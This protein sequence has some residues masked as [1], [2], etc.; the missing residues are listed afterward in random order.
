M[1][2]FIHL[3]V[4][5][6][7]SMLESALTV[8]KIVELAKAE[9]M[10]AVAM[11]DRGNLFGSLEFAISCSKSGVQPIIGSILNLSTEGL[12]KEEKQAFA[13]I[14]LIAKNDTGYKNLLKLVSYTFIKNDRSSCNHITFKDLTE[15]QEGL[16]ALSCYT[17][18]FIG[19]AL[20]A[21][22][23]EKAKEY[24][25]MLQVLFGDRFYFEIMRDTRGDAAAIE[26]GYLNLALEM[27]IPLVAT[28]RVLFSD[29]S[30]HDAH[31]TL[32]CIS[33]GVTKENDNRPRASNQCYFK[34]TSEM[35]Q[36]FHDLPEAIENSI[37]IA[38]RCH[39]MPEPHPPMLPNFG[40]TE[41]SE[42]DLI[43]EES[44]KGLRFR[45]EGKF[46]LEN[47]S[48]DDQEK[49]TKE[50]FARLEYEL[51]IITKMK[52]S[53]YFLIVSDFIKWSKEHNISVGPGR[54]SGAGSIV[55]WCLLITDLDPI[56]FGLLF[57]RFLNPERISMPDFDIDFCQERREEV[58]SYV[59][60]K[61][62]DERVG[63]IIT[64]G[65][66]QAKAVIKDV[67]RVLG[68]KYDLANH[69]TD[70][71]PFN[72]VNPVT[73]AQAIEEVAE[74]GEASKGRG[75]YNFRGDEELIK[76][77]LET[78]LTLE[79]LHRHASTHAA[80]I[81]IAGKDLIEVVP[82]YKDA[83]S[84]MLV[85]QYS[86]KYA[87]AAGLMKFD[88]LGLQTL[89]IITK[90]LELLKA[91]GIE[92][93]FNN[94]LYDDPQTY[95]LLSTGQSTGVFQFESVGM[96]D[97]LRRLRPDNINDIIALGALYRP[98]PMDN[99]PTYIACKHGK[100]QPDYLHPSLKDILESTYGVII[101]QEQVQ[102]IA[103][104][105]AGYTL[106]AA[107]LLRRAMGKKIK[108]EMQAQEEMFISGAKASGIAEQQA[109][110]IFETLAKFA[111]YGFNKAHAAAYGVISYQTAYLKA[112]FTAEFLVACLN[113]DIDNQDK[114]SLF[115]QEAKKF[116]I[117]V[118]VV[119]V[120][121]SKSYFE[122]GEGGIIYALG[123]IKNVA[124]GL[125]RAIAEERTRKGK[126]TSIINFVERM[127]QKLVNKRALE[128]L[129]KAGAFDQLHNNRKQLL[130]SV[131]Q[132]LSYCSSYHSEQNSDQFS[133]IAVST[134]SKDILIAT[135][136]ASCYEL[137]L[138]EFD[139]LGAF[140][141][142]HPITEYKELLQ[143]CGAYDSSYIQTELPAGQ[144]SIKIAGIIQ[145]KDARMS[146]RG[147]F[148][149]LQLSD[150]EGIFE[151]TV[152]SEEVLKNYAHLLE[153]K[154]IVI[155]TCDLFKDEGG[156]RLTARSF[157][158]LEETLQ[159]NR[160]ELAL[161][162][163]DN[164]EVQE[165]I[166]FIQKRVNLEKTNA[167]ITIMLETEKNFLAKVDMP[168]CFY[169]DAEDV[170]SLKRFQ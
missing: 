32:L 119:D 152:F 110:S 90:C 170:V 11:T 14:L 86:M 58:I 123:A 72:A 81:V 121:S 96:K 113:L 63:Q 88:F 94:S 26:A 78:A 37:C 44:E 9:G 17:E 28:N 40:S 69:L 65:K 18:G 83:A 146:A 74:L 16:I 108:V 138:A 148:V 132:I 82:V 85:V 5:S 56:K 1:P 126:F 133:L 80:G 35:K 159:K 23:K 141:T 8:D 51:D 131:E 33:A 124:I 154:K 79:G 27:N 42:D 77:V 43:K 10:P 64:F 98:G 66:M 128:G 36:L 169:L 153:T 143:N 136:H 92:V 120:N 45:L 155:A 103:K 24:A 101:Y 134:V 118:T 52:F 12:G 20:A 75:L 149:T 109:K 127:P 106:G 95:E 102:E 97:T 31:D 61:Y 29:V 62:G 151:I 25:K 139:A 34:S 84:D 160:F 115:I 70:L 41:I 158:S 114:I 104:V 147:R 125:G 39:V 53:G 2:D 30:M 60:S 166:N 117:P 111:G 89:T 140:M 163:K 116:N 157:S 7:Y 22:K 46:R 67:S 161:Y 57:E 156:I 71:V 164:S 167:D 76:Q 38:K 129:I 93:D 13:E 145:K 142:F 15:Y 91:R 165:I 100:Q 21:G 137:A 19:K 107:D 50:Y 87:E 99:I 68:L 144:H 73:L 162:P 112:N 59:R 135:E 48:P 150:P 49:I 6:S 55:A 47:I 105:L 4:Q 3:R 122:A 168:D 54:G 130:I